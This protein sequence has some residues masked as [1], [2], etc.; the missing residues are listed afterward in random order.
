MRRGRGERAHGERVTTDAVA[1]A[2]GFRGRGA[3]VLNVSSDLRAR[4][5][6]G[7]RGVVARDA[8]ETRARRDGWVEHNF[9]RRHASRAGAERRWR[10]RKWALSSRLGE[11]ESA[12]A[13]ARVGAT[14][15]DDDGDD[16]DDVRVCDRPGHDEHAMRGV[17][18]VDAARGGELRGG[19][20]ASVGARAAVS[21]AW[22][23]RARRE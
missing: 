4:D 11:V 16:D 7:C 14:D 12:H 17:R 10:A 1:S 21:R 15:D 6:R 9:T 23:V 3:A 13:D 8:R 18:D 20:E 2:S 5:A 19:G 22:V